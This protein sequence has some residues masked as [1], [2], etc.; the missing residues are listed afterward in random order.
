MGKKGVLAHQETVILA[1]FKHFL[2]GEKLN[3]A[4]LLKPYQKIEQQWAKEDKVRFVTD[5]LRGV[6]IPKDLEDCFNQINS[7]WSDSIKLKVKQLTEEE[8]TGRVHHGFGTW[9]RNNWQLWAGSRL[10]KYF[11]EKG[12]Q[13]PDDMSG[14]ILDSYHR[15]LNN[16]PLKLDEQI[17]YYINYW[18]KAK[19]EELESKRVDFAEYVIGDTVA[20]LYRQGYSSKGQ[21]DKYDDDSCIATGRIIGLNTKDF[22]VHIKL[23]Q[24]CDKKGIV[25][26]D[27]EDS[28]VYNKKTGKLEKPKKRKILYMRTGQERW[29][30]YADWEVD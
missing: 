8:F 4:A 16:K 22:F 9:M 12:I 29:F 20:F 23:L 7:F 19:K 30:D 26:Y 25:Y 21:E 28:R 13:H 10:S 3:E 11:N 27:N 24:S 18:E 1:A 14:I 6:Y 2:L 15:T 5:S 17:V